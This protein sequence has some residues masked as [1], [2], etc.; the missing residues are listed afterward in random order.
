MVPIQ[1]SPFTLFLK[2]SYL[3][4]KT[5]NLFVNLELNGFRNS[6]K[7]WTIQYQEK[8]RGN[9]INVTNVTWVAGFGL[10]ILF[11]ISEAW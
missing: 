3:L 8:K 7:A 10:L 2:L 5:Y 1:K 11:A 9:H 6:F 4:Y